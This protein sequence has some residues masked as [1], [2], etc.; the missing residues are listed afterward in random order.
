M[1]RRVLFTASTFSHIRN[2]HLPYLNAF[3]ELGWEVHVACGGVGEP[4]PYA[5]R[6]VSLPLQKRMWALSNFKAAHTLRDMIRAEGYSLISTHTSLA[7]FFTRLAVKGLAGRPPVV[8]MVHGYLFDERTPALK[9]A[10]LLMAER[11]T[12]VETDLL[13]TMNRWDCELAKRYSLGREIVE[14]P[15]V[16]V[17]FSRLDRGREEGGALRKGLGIPEDAVVLIYPA[18]FSKRKSQAVLIQAMVKLPERTVLV[19]PG[20]G[21][22][23]E[24]CRALADSLG[25]RDRLIFPGYVREMAPWYGMADIAV[26]S[27]RSEGLPF[28]VMEAMYC[29]LPAAA[30]AVKG[31]VDLICH[32]ETGLLYP[33][34]DAEACAAVI[35]PLIDDAGLRNRLSAA[36]PKN[37]ENRALSYVLPKV[38]ELYLRAADWKPSIR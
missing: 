22:L 18:E 4:V 34:G 24:R 1:R 15:G 9:R 38:M 13:M 36:A 30:S 14:I 20:E 31:H 3:R 8:N 25:L 21:A 23:W 27:S 5:D 11:L 28:N 33:Y 17:D 12:A 10:V 37:V 35:Q 26:S 29:G 19:L 16:G 32:G 6:T 7:A 2:F